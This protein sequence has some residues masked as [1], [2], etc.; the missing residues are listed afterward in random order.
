MFALVVALSTL[1]AMIPVLIFGSIQSRGEKRIIRVL[2]PR[3][4]IIILLLPSKR[5][6]ETWRGVKVHLL[7]HIMDIGRLTQEIRR[8]ESGTQV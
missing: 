8:S 1:G 7:L 6:P 2:D 5:L 3:A 4:F